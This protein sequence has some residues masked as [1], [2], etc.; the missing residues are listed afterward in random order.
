MRDEKRFGALITVGAGAATVGATIE[1]VLAWRDVATAIARRAVVAVEW[2][3]ASPANPFFAVA[4]L[5][6]AFAVWVSITSPIT[7]PQQEDDL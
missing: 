5:C 2:L 6:L 1:L 3:T 4:L 7:I